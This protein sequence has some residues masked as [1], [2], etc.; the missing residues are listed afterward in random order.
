MRVSG[1]IKGGLN[2]ATVSNGNAGFTPTGIHF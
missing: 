2:F 1:G